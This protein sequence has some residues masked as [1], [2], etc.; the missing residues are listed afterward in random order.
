M[1]I[2]VMVQGAS[3]HHFLLVLAPGSV[4]AEGMTRRPAGE[5]SAKPL[6]VGNLGMSAAGPGG[7]VAAYWRERDV[8]K[9]VRNVRSSE[10]FNARSSTVPWNTIRTRSTKPSWPWRT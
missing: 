6:A 4:L 2:L 10:I 3:G 1:G 7:K 8:D 5:A 9:K